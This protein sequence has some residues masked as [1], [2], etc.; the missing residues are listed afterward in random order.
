M[1]S[2]QHRARTATT[3]ARRRGT[4]RT[5]LAGSAVLLAVL[6]ACGP[7]GPTLRPAAA[8]QAAS[9]PA[10]TATSAGTST[11]ASTS[12]PA[13]TPA[14]PTPVSSTPA[15]APAPVTVTVEAVRGADGFW[16]VQGAAALASGAPA[17]GT[18]TI[19]LDATPLGT[20]PLVD[21]RVAVA[22]PPALGPGEHVL[23]ARFTPAD[24]TRVAAAETS[25]PLSI[26]KAGAA[27]SGTAV[28]ASG[29]GSVRYGDRATV[30]VTVAPTVPTPDLGGPVTLLD[31]D[32]VLAEGAADP[33]GTVDLEYLNRA[34]PGPH[35]YRIRYAGNA[36]VDPA[37][38]ALTLQSTQ[39]NVDLAISTPE[40][41]TK[42]LPGTDVPLVVSVI[43]TPDKP[44]GQ[45]VVSAD[46]TQ[47]AAGTLDADG[48]FRATLP[49]ITE[50]AHT[51]SVSYAGDTRFQPG[52]GEKAI[53]AT[54]PPVNP[55]ASAAAGLQAANPCPASASACVDLS[56][57][58]A[59]LQSN[60][61][62]TY[63]PVPIT[64]GRSGYRTGAGT[65]EVFWRDKNHKSSIFNNAP[66]PN[67]VFFDGGIA[68]HQ[69][70]LSDQS[71]GCIHLS[72]AASETFFDTLSVGDDVV[73][74]GSAP[75]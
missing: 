31:G 19:D 52:Q 47:L 64:S 69:G 72:G 53:T 4:A 36:S 24:A 28:T 7:A 50:G 67:S 32:T 12:T 70:S 6:T 63:G 26:A 16:T 18:L 25:T 35:D 34:D 23:L 2:D 37:D 38:G 41:S 45:V 40:T 13:S 17:D 56:S 20:Q 65:F 42:P 43:G 57:Q 74:W 10:T 55:A 75:Y 3:R 5:A 30:R 49:A 8:T 71:H 1:S 33:T 46:G 44:T 27:V 9:A 22:T 11:S 73:V 61:T 21:G 59:W 68:F 51:V 54:T 29:A 48:T 58:Q 15:P 60:G 14:A 66:M 62:I 39:T